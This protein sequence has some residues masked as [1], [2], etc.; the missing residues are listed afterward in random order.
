MAIKKA[1]LGYKFGRLDL[2]MSLGLQIWSRKSLNANAL[3][4]DLSHDLSI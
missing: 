3:I 1:G 2:N 4:N